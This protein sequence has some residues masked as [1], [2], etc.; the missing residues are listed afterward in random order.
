VA[1]NLFLDIDKQKWG[2]HGWLFMV[3]LGT[4]DVVIEHNTGF[5]TGALM[6]VDPP[7]HTGFVFRHNVVGHGEYGVKGSDLASGEPTLRAVF[8]DPR[9]EGNVLIGPGSARYPDGNPSVRGIKD[10]G[11]A[12]A[13]RGDWRLAP[14]SRFKG[15]AGGRDPGAD[16]D[17]IANATGV[18]PRV[19]SSSGR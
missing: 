13:E 10:V 17:R 12:D 2:G 1:N 3:I 11:F 6:A 4:R 15:A 8:A 14:N 18:G 9:F 5:P 19:M 16:L 7:V